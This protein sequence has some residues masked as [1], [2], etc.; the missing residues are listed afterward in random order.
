MLRLSDQGKEMT[1]MLHRRI[2]AYSAKLTEDIGKEDLRKFEA[3]ASQI[4]ANYAAM[5]P[6]P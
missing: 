5:K 2:Q 6:Q 3:V 1:S 4:V